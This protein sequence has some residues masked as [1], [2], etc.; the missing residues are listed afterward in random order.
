MGNALP[1]RFQNLKPQNMAM[2]FSAKAMLAGHVKRDGTQTVYIQAIINRTVARVNLGFCVACKDFDADKGLIKKEAPNADLLNFQI[3]EG[4]A[5]AHKIYLDFKYNDRFLTP[6][7]FRNEFVDPSLM[8]DF[9]RFM[10]SEIELRKSKLEKVTYGAHITTLNKMKSFKKHILFHELTVEFIQKM[11]NE[12]IQKYKLKANT[13][14]KVFR[15]IKV[16]LHLAERKGIRFKN[17][18]KDYK[19]KSTRPQK[20]ILSFEEVKRLFAYFHSED[21]KASHRKVLRYFLFSCCTGVR[22]SDISLLEWNHLHDDTLVF[23]PYKTRKGG[24]FISIPLTR[25]SLSLIEDKKGSKFLFDCFAKQVTN[26]ILKEIAVVDEV[27]IKKDM[28]YHISRHTFATEFMDRGGQLDTL[29]QLL[30]HSM[31]TT[32]MQYDKVKDERK[33]DELEKAFNDFDAVE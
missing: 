9:V 13:V 20:P 17:P 27:N 8:M 10:E 3:T 2:R 30:G 16:Y 18:F 1:N 6:E 28:T 21:I 24:K 25:V 15:I 11:E 14:H 5:K 32:T 26:R 22:I 31:I 12:F 29:Q 19:I 4:I 23:L 7:L 33:R